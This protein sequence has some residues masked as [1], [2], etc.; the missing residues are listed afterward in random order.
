MTTIDREQIKLS[1][2]KREA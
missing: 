1:K 2:D